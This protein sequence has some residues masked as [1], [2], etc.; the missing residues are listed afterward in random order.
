[1]HR[2]ALVYVCWTTIWGPSVVSC[3]EPHK[4]DSTYRHY[5]QWSQDNFREGYVTDRYF[6]YTIGNPPSEDGYLWDSERQE[7]WDAPDAMVT[8]GRWLA[9]LALEYNLTKDTETL[10]EIKTVVDFFLRLDRANGKTDGF[11]VR[12][13][14]PGH[15]HAPTLDQY[16]GML[17]GYAMVWNYVDDFEIRKSVYRHAQ[18]I[19]QYFRRHRYLMEDPEGKLIT[20]FVGEKGTTGL[21][22]FRWPMNR[23]LQ[24]I[25]G[26]SYSVT[27]DEMAG[28]I[29]DNYFGTIGQFV[30]PLVRKIIK[31]NVS[32]VGVDCANIESLMELISAEALVIIAATVALDPVVFVTLGAPIATAYYEI[33]NDVRNDVLLAYITTALDSEELWNGI[34]CAQARIVRGESICILGFKVAELDPTNNY[35]NNSH[36]WMATLAADDCGCGTRW[37]YLSA[38]ARDQ[39][40][41]DPFNVWFAVSAK[42]LIRRAMSKGRVGSSG[43]L[44]NPRFET[45]L[46][47]LSRFPKNELPN[48]RHFYR[49]VDSWPWSGAGK[50]RE[51]D[52]CTN[53][54]SIVHGK[55]YM[56]PYLMK[57]YD[58]INEPIRPATG[59]DHDQRSMWGDDYARFQSYRADSIDISTR[60]SNVSVLFRFP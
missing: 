60:F 32:L 16:L 58:E 6:G 31:T 7:Y 57:I 39:L 9:S 43:L 13:D 2:I 41:L 5:R 46:S 28:Y 50:E 40:N 12:C 29:E 18:R 37:Q 52:S 53:K 8:S 48:S 59:G 55:G 26:E 27:A 30:F 25:T 4:F 35:Y 56:L 24:H 34:V 3:Q 10:K 44:F 49:S 22:A 45:A 14:L 51:R 38:L 1:M 17:F 54:G 33:S 11:L 15:E 23:V 42:H 21:Y 47:E 36:I 20:S 19:G